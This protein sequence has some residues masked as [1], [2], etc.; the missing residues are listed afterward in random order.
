VENEGELWFFTT[1][2]SGTA[3]D[4][5]EEHAVN[6]SYSEPERDHYVSVS[7]Q[8]TV[9]MDQ[10]KARHLWAEELARYFPKGLHEP[11]LALLRVRI[12]F[13]EYWDA[14]ASKMRPLTN[15]EGHSDD[16][17]Q[18]GRKKAG[19][20]GTGEREGQREKGIEHTKVEIRATPASG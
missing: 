20:S 8:A 19:A 10:A 9:V 11:H 4:L 7:G 6:I 3:H 5:A 17:A 14:S 2:E 12:E 16:L 13:A 1:D 15:P 18:S